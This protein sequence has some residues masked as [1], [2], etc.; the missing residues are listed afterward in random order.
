MMAIKHGLLYNIM[1]YTFSKLV[2]F[3]NFSNKFI[4]ETILNIFKIDICL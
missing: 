4:T 1:M 3:K 2:V